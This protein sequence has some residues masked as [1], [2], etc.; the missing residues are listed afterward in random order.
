MKPSRFRTILYLAGFKKIEIATQPS[1]VMAQLLL[2]TGK[3]GVGKSTVSAA[4]AQH[5]ASQGYRT[6]LVSSDPAHSTDDT[7]GV[8]V[9]PSVVQIAPNFWA[10]NID[11]ER[12]ARNFTDTLNRA[13]SET[14]AKMLPGLDS[15]LFSDMAGFPGMDEYFALEE[16]LRLTQSCDY[17]VVVFDTAPTGHTLR[18]LT[19]PDYIKTFLLKILRMKAKIENFKGVL[20]KRDK[21]AGRLADLLEEVCDK[22]DRLKALLRSEW[23]TV[24]LVSIASEAGLQECYRTIRFLESQQISVHNIVVNNIIPNFGEATWKTTQG[25]EPNRAAQLIKCEYDIQQ[26]YL[27][28]YQEICDAHRINLVG[29]SRLPYEPRASR[30]PDYSKILW[31]ESRGISF[32]PRKSLTAEETA[33][34]V[35]VPFLDSAK[36]TVA[37]GKASYA[38]ED[39][40]MGGTSPH[41]QVPI[42]AA[43]GKISR[44]KNANG[45]RLSWT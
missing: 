15:E 39:F 23:V 34:L 22:I 29:V 27:L 35:S 40:N 16:I 45:V 42:P 12:M 14:F 9:G 10:K 2:Y 33:V 25:D 38:W 30:L 19:A 28:K 43:A 4:S 24:N 41:Y 37:D 1:C 3:G 44:R 5:L 17:D 26:P 18:A 7:L 13:T 20:F 21:T 11:A 8:S 6:I 36:W 31:H 32:Q